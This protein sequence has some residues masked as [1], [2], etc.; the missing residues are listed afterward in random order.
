MVQNGGDVGEGA[1]AIVVV[2]DIF[3][4]ERQ[5]AIVGYVEVQETVLV[6]VCPCAGDAVFLVCNAGGE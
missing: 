2:E 3:G 6:E 1:V 4:V 5:G